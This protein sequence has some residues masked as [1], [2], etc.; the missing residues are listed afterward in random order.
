MF[1]TQH[2]TITTIALLSMAC[3]GEMTEAEHATETAEAVSE[4]SIVEC[5][6]RDPASCER[7]ESCLGVG[8]GPDLYVCATDRC[9]SSRECDDGYVCRANH[10]LRVER[11]ANECP[12]GTRPGITTCAR[13]YTSV[14][15]SRRPL[16]STCEEVRDPCRPD[17]RPTARGTCRRVLGYYFNGRTCAP[18]SGCRV[19]D[20]TGLFR[21]EAHCARAYHRC[22]P[23]TGGR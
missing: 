5:S 3:A 20:A 9:R 19:A 22:M 7:G 21:T 15:V 14:V 11:D 12:R 23:R 6:P 17:G 1:Q 18:L 10:C 8:A 16:C 13:G 2:A 4:L